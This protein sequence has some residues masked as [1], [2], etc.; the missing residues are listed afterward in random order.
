MK[1]ATF[2]LNGIKTR[3]SQLLDWLVRQVPAVV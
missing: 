1:L 3:L 2:N